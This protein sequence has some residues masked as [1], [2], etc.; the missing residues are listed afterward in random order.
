MNA[1][2]KDK[3]AKG[4]ASALVSGAE[5]EGIDYRVYFS[6]VVLQAKQE[7]RERLL[8][9][10][11]EVRNRLCAEYTEERKHYKGVKFKLEPEMSFILIFF[12][13]RFYPTQELLSLLF[14][15]SRT[16]VNRLLPH[17]NDLLYIKLKHLVD[18]ESAEERKKDHRMI[19]AHIV[20]GIVDGTEQESM[21]PSTI[22]LQALYY[23][24]KKAQH[25]FTKVAGVSA[26][27]KILLLSRSFPG[28]I[29]DS[30]IMDSLMP[31]LETALADWE[32]WIGDKGFRKVHPR[33][34]APTSNESL[35]REFSS[36]RIKVENVFASMKQY[37]ICRDT[38]RIAISSES[39]SAKALEL[40]H[41]YYT[42]VAALVNLKSHNSKY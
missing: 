3:M 14:P 10:S 9:V 13:Y 36:V 20:T 25:S 32:C 11:D 6:K 22:T 31:T 42:I 38:L 28:S 35:A 29:N 8:G 17:L 39:D 1:V 23:S 37:A 33:I 12:F 41:K 2:E 15:I 21:K 34:L 40:H 5:K 18:M 7:D 19:L 24:V 30:A 16:S 27:G 26:S 4:I